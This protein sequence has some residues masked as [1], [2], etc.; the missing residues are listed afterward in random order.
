MTVP[1]RFALLALVGGSVCLVAPE[2]QAS[3]TYPGV[4]EDALA[5]PCPPACTTCHTRPEGGELTANTPFGIS[6]RR[7]GLH[8]CNN[9]ELLDVLAT[10]DANGTDSDADGTP[11]TEE[12]RAGT[13]PNALE[14]K[15]ECY[16]PESDE[17]C[18][19]SCRT[20]SERGRAAWAF[21]AL[22][23]VIGIARMRRGARA[24]QS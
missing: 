11:D 22:V 9:S 8:C 12:L 17:G 2:A 4:I 13:D 23:A 18:A 6:V 14:G 16:V 20:P 7:A 19:M 1:F 15:L 3:E 5:T 24:R 10:L 21:G